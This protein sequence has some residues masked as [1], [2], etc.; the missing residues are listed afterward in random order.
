MSLNLVAIAEERTTAAADELGVG[1]KE[2][3]ASPD[4]TSTSHQENIPLSTLWVMN[5]WFVSIPKVTSKPPMQSEKVCFVHNA[6]T[7]PKCF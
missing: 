4:P 6:I 1:I 7:L 3:L 5:Y 2:A